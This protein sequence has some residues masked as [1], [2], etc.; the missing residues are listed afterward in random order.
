MTIQCYS[1]F[2][3]PTFNVA[4]REKGKGPNAWGLGVRLMRCARF[5]GSQQQPWC[6]V[7]NSTLMAVPTC[8]KSASSLQ[9]S[10]RTMTV[11]LLCMEMTVMPAKSA[12]PQCS[13]QRWASHLVGSTS[14]ANGTYPLSWK[15][16]TV[17]GF[18]RRKLASERLRRWWWPASTITVGRVLIAS[19][20]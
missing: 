1:S 14:I 18:I 5:N 12:L 19:I 2:P 17:V 15:E 3:L 4:C 7:S 6:V 10:L 20:Y 8:I 11:L 16:T 9:E 13:N